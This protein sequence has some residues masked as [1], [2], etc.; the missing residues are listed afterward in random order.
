[1]LEIN[2][3]IDG[4]YTVLD[5]IGR[6]GMSIVYLVMNKS[7]GQMWALKEVRKDAGRDENVLKQGLVAELDILLKL[8]HPNLPRI[9]DLID[10]QD[11]FLIVMDYIEGVSLN[12]LVSQ[13]G[14]LPQKDVIWYGMQLC[15]VLGYLHSRTPPIIYRDMK[16]ANVMLRPDG[17][18]SLIDFG[19]AREYKMSSIEDTTCLGTVGY[20]AP[21]QFGGR[22]QSDARTDIYCLGATLYELV[23]GKSPTLPPYEMYPIRQINPNL[24]PTLEKIIIK[25]TDPNPVNRYQSCAELFA[26]LSEVELIDSGAFEKGRKNLNIFLGCAVAAGVLCLVTIIMAIL[27]KSIVFPLILTVPAVLAGAGLF[28]Y[29]N[30]SETHRLIT[31]ESR[32]RIIED[33]NA[34]YFQT[35]RLMETQNNIPSTNQNVFADI[36]NTPPVQNNISEPPPEPSPEP[37]SEPDIDPKEGI[38]STQLLSNAPMNIPVSKYDRDDA[39]TVYADSIFEEK[40]AAAESAANAKKSVDDSQ[41][42]QGKFNIIEEK[43]FIHTDEII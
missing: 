4:K 43:M 32:K 6:G 3:I 33:L 23:T 14:A 34:N 27:G 12:K 19:T 10:R 28:K 9:V 26:A 5:E 7:T 25:C 24:S 8:S 20:A 40:L 11:T 36:N 17:T 30:I 39:A 42:K 38:G 35:G 16:P 41:P 15:D 31:G 1:M 37:P 22:G 29:F 2:Q 13:K 21:E 18:V